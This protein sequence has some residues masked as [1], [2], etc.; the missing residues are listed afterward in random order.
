VGL[1]HARDKRLHTYSKGMLQRIGLAQSIL[2]DPEIIF[3]DEPMSGLDP[4]GRK[5]VKD[6]MI[7]LK[8]QGKTLFFNT[9]ILSDVE[10]LCDRFAI[11]SKGEL[12]ADMKVRDLREPI[13]DFFMKKIE[14]NQGQDFLVH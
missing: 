5:M 10:I 12:I 1:L 7:E 9:H 13:E 3:L 8:K 2:H 11:I 14:E 4:I 6:L